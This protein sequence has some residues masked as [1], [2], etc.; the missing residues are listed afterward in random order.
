MY[1]HWHGI[2]RFLSHL[3][4][5]LPDTDQTKLIFGTDGE[6]ALTN[7][8]ESCFPASRHLKDN[9]R[10][11]WKNSLANPEVQDIINSLFNKSTGLFTLETDDVYI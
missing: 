8:I 9:L 2:T 6:N 5:Q 3:Q 11:S 10:H 4:I 7:A 1:L